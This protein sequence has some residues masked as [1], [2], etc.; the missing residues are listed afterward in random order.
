MNM[1]FVGGEDGLFVF[2]PCDGN[3]E[4]IEYKY[5]MAYGAAYMGKTSKN[6]RGLSEVRSVQTLHLPCG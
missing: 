5:P 6:I 3:T 4:Y 1:V 2:Q